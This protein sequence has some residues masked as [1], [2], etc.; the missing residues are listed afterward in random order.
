MG[1][2]VNECF[3]FE[4]SSYAEV[5]YLFT[6]G[7]DQRFNAIADVIEDEIVQAVEQRY[8]YNWKIGFFSAG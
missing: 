5:L 6:L 7:E 2:I 4:L 8:L 3:S 1:H